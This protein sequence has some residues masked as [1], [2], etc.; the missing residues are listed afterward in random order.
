MPNLIEYI[1]GTATTEQD[2]IL[3][4]EDFMVNVLTG[5]S[6]IDKNTDTASDRDYIFYSQGTVPGRYRD[7]Y[8]RWRGYSDD[9]RVYGYQRWASSADYDAELHDTSY[10]IINCGAGPFNYWVF[11]D[12]DGVWLIIKD[13][14]S[15]WS[16]FGGYFETY[17]CDDI[18]DL[19]TCVVGHSSLSSFFTSPRV[20]GYGPPPV[21]SGYKTSYVSNSAYYTTYLT[22]GEPNQRDGSVAHLPIIMAHSTNNAEKEIRG[23]LKHSL[24]FGGDTLASEDWVTISGTNYK[25]FISKYGADTTFGVGPITTLSGEW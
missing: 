5:W 15:Y 19:P 13:G 2:L 11:G 4:L 3:A 20:Y 7:L 18:D 14:T 6:V 8:I 23:E 16:G 21:G 1:T 24:W 25:Y 9:V 17:Y 10:N 12:A 22:Y